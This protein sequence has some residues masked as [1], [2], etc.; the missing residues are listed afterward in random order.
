LDVVL[1]QPWRQRLLPAVPS[2]RFWIPFVVPQAESAVQFSI[3]Q[4]LSPP[5]SPVAR[6]VSPLLHVLWLPAVVHAAP[7][8]PLAEATQ[9]VPFPE[10]LV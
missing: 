3:V 2:H 10:G 5:V 1:V 6:H 8:E 4:K 9:F 7:T